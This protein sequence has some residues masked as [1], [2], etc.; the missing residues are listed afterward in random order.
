MVNIHYL[1][2]FFWVKI[3]VAHA[4]YFY[5]ASDPFSQTQNNGLIEAEGLIPQLFTSVPALNE[6]ATYV[7]QTTSYLTSC[8]SDSSGISLSFYFEFLLLSSL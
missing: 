2:V 7:A 1:L 8:F 6:A 4:F 3:V 5:I